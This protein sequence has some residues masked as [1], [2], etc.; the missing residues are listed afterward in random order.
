MDSKMYHLAVTEE[1]NF[2]RAIP[3]YLNK[4]KINIHIKRQWTLILLRLAYFKKKQS[5]YIKMEAN[6]FRYR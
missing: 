4:N 2:D 6:I 5:K 1:A 3:I